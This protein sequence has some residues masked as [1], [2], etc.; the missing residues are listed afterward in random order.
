MTLET[1]LA[2]FPAQTRHRAGASAL[3]PCPAH[4]DRSASLS[5]S[6]GAD[7]RILVHCFAGCGVTAITHALKLR[8][9]DLFS[10]PRVPVRLRRPLT[11]L[12][13]AFRRAYREARRQEARWEPWRAA[14]RDAEDIRVGRQAAAALRAHVTKTMHPDDEAAWELLAEAAAWETEAERL[15][16]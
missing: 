8:V 1:F 2:L 3:V 4:M 15:D 5:V 12:E 9:G 6:A 14:L 10:D 7:G 11:E 13:W 16:S